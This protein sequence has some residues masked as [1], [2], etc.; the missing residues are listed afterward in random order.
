MSR[1]R[2]EVVGNTVGA[3]RSTP[4]PGYLLNIRM[5]RSGSGKATA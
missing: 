4:A 1:L 2:I 5:S 3:F